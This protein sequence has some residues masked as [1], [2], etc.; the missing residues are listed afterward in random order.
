MRLLPIAVATVCLP[1]FAASV[2]SLSPATIAAASEAV[3]V[4]DVGAARAVARGRTI[5]T[6]VDVVVVDVLRGAPLRFDTIVVAGGTLAD[7][8]VKVSNQPELVRGS[9]VIVGVAH[10]NADVVVVGGALGVLPFSTTAAAEALLTNTT[11]RTPPRLLRPLFNVDGD[12]WENTD[13]QAVAEGFVFDAASFTDL[14]TEAVAVAAFQYTLDIWND[15]GGA[16]VQLRYGGLYDNNAPEPAIVTYLGRRSF[17]SAIAQTSTTTRGNLIV[18]CDIQLF[19]RNIYGTIDF[20]FDLAGA[21]DGQIDFFQDVTHEIGHCLGLSHSDDDNAVMAPTL[22]TGTGDER[23][24]LADDDSAG[25]QSLYGVG[26]GEGEGEGESGEGEGEGESGEGE[27]EG[28]SGEGEGEGEGEPGA[29]GEGEG[30]AAEPAPS[31]CTQ[32]R[33]DVAALAV[34]TL[35]ALRR[36]RR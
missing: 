7:Q 13:S 29:E 11:A 8:R 35:L 28:E 18:A 25:L 1:A 10:D 27:G 31:S 36:R 33:D 20:S 4:V 22:A 15:E 5:V 14:A 2:Q 30:E 23:R 21:G 19:S 17:S 26:V 32:A 9:R 6:V 3:V 34:I 24:H 12:H 16:D